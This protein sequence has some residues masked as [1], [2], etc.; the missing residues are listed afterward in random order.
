V[1]LFHA[2]IAFQRLIWA[3]TE[4]VPIAVL[5]LLVFETCAGTSITKSSS[6][7]LYRFGFHLISDQRSLNTSLGRII[8]P[9]IK[10]EE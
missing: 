8:V 7:G 6:S 3:A 1:R 2:E 5:C 4:Q 10:S 9:T